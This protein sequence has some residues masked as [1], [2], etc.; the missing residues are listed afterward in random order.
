MDKSFI[1]KHALFVICL[2]LILAM[3]GVGVFKLVQSFNVFT[4]KKMEMKTVMLQLRQLT[5]HD[6]YPSLENVDIEKNNYRDLLNSC[7]ELNKSI[8]DNHM[9][10]QEMD[11]ADFMSLLENTLQRMRDQLSKKHIYFPEKFDFGFG[12]YVKGEMPHESDVPLLVQRLQIIEMLNT[13]LCAAN[14]TE[15]IALSYKESKSASEV[16]LPRRRRGRRTARRQEKREKVPAGP[17]AFFT[18]QHFKIIFRATE[19][20]MLDF[21]NLLARLPA[22]TVITDLELTNQKTK[23]RVPARSSSGPA[24]AGAGIASS[25]EFFLYGKRKIVSGREEVNLIIQL[26]IYDFEPSFLVETNTVSKTTL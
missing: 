4:R 26:D 22:F 23:P 18:T 25:N 15:L 19:D 2:A 13:T 8:G 1:K 9:P 14:I 5:R 24:P 7:A 12:R 3:L 10:L 16:I 11:P 17:K 21:L 6:P 20:S